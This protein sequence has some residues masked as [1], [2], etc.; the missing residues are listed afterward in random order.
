MSQNII[1][2]P[3]LSQPFFSL[4]LELTTSRRFIMQSNDSH[5]IRGWPVDFFVTLV[6]VLAALVLHYPNHSTSGCH[7]L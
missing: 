4:S 3:M 2:T 6:V 5:K 1:V 7:S